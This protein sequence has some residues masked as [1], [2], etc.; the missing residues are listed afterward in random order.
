[1]LS[2]DQASHCTCSVTACI[3]QTLSF[4]YKLKTFSRTM[5][6]HVVFFSS[7]IFQKGREEG[8]CR[9]FPVSID[10]LIT[11]QVLS[12]LQIVEIACQQLHHHSLIL[13]NSL[14]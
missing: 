4:V 12:D 6:F 11:Q 9:L 2:I 10:I 3:S 1:M 7:N 14:F 5:L 13:N 8:S